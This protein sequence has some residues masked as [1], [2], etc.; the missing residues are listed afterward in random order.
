M[1]A[2]MT[3]A[4]VYQLVH[5]ALDM[6]SCSQTRRVSSAAVNVLRATQILTAA[7]LSATAKLQRTTAQ[8]WVNRLSPMMASVRVAVPCK[9]S[10]AVEMATLLQLRISSV[11]ANAS[12]GTVVTSVSIRFATI[13]L[14]VIT[15]T[16]LGGHLLLPTPASVA[17][18]A[19]PPWEMRYA[20]TM[21]SWTKQTT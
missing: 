8:V 10:S 12:Q 5:F 6:A 9:E 16:T 17:V 4:T 11:N 3:L 1:H 2:I 18:S 13:A 19:M 14:E 15:A 20:A 21:D 7:R